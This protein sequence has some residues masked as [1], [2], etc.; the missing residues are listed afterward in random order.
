MNVNVSY[1]GFAASLADMIEERVAEGVASAARVISEEA[2]QRCPVDTGN[3]RD[4][5]SVETDGQKAV[6]TAT[7]DYAAY[8]E[9]GTSKAAAQPF[10]VP[11]ILE[12]ADA[13]VSAIGDA[14]SG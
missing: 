13:A 2:R 9:F 5:I 14:L 1:D 8:V 12:S 4:S 10:L 6:V 7:A 11:A 3:L